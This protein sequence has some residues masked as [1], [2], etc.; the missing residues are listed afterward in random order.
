[1]SG[2]DSIAGHH[3]ACPVPFDECECEDLWFEED[4]GMD[5]YEEMLF[6]N[7]EDGWPYD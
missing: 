6:N 2:N 1:M 3:P 7:S 5:L 4:S